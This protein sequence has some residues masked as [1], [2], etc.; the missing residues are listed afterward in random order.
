MKDKYPNGASKE[1][2]DLIDQMLLELHQWLRNPKSFKRPRNK[3][4]PYR[5]K[6]TKNQKSTIPSL[7]KQGILHKQVK[8]IRDQLFD[9]Y[10]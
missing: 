8:Q 3:N 6:E 7:Y 5:R 4:R 10:K 1:E 2:K 9:L